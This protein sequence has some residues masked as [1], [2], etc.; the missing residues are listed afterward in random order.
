[1]ARLEAANERFHVRQISRNQPLSGGIKLDTAHT[2]LEYIWLYKG[3]L[4]HQL[5]TLLCRSPYAIGLSSVRLFQRRRRRSASHPL[6]CFSAVYA[7]RLSRL[8]P[9]RGT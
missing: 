2:P 7:K 1:M 4:E 6:H 8:F 5:E 9:R 3:H